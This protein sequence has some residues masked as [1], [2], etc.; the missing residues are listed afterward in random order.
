MIEILEG[1]ANRTVTYP[2]G[3]PRPLWPKDIAPEWRAKHGAGLDAWMAATF[4]PE[5]VTRPDP[6]DLSHWRTVRD[7]AKGSDV[8]VVP[9]TET[10]EEI[11]VYGFII[12]EPATGKELHRQAPELH[13]QMPE[14]TNKAKT[15]SVASKMRDA[16]QLGKPKAEVIAE[17]DRKVGVMVEGHAARLEKFAALRAIAEKRSG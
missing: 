7:V 17:I 4:L 6:E 2:D 8:V 3:A 9:G 13:P 12:A 1:K 15:N 10:T 11:A 14:L 5:G 16:L